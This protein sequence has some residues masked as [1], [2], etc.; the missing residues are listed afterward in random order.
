M[1]SHLVSIRS[2]LELQGGV[3]RERRE[4]V[5]IKKDKIL[6]FESD[7]TS[8]SAAGHVLIEHVLLILHPVQHALHWTPTSIVVN[9]GTNCE[10]KHTWVY[11]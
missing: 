8:C 6:K 5:R 3:G 10:M 11:K 1:D 7:K 9:S 2:C 4:D